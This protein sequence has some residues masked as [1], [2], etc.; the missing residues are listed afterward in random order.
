MKEWRRVGCLLGTAKQG[1]GII[2]PLSTRMRQEIAKIDGSACC[3]CI[4]GEEPYFPLKD[5]NDCNNTFAL[6][7]LFYNLAYLCLLMRLLIHVAMDI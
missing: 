3:I 6:N 5:T 2:H 7:S 1:L 4:R